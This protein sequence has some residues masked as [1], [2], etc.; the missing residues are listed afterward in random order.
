MRRPHAL[1]LTAAVVLALGACGKSPQRVEAAAADAAGER[2]VLAERT[3][4]DLKPVAALVTT[5]DMAEARARI[6]GTLVR[7]AVK[8]GDQVRKGQVVA[9][10][11]DQRLAF[12]TRAYEG[13]VAAA[14]AEATRAKAD[15]ARIQTLYDQGVYAEA[16]LEQAA[17]AA[18]AAQGQLDAVR[19]QRSAAAELVGQGDVL[20]P[21]SGRVLR[22][23]A[24][25]GSVV[26]PG[27]SVATIT[28]G[29]PLLRLEI[30]EA[31]A[32]A[33]RVGD[34]VPIMVEDL[35]G[36]G[37]AGVIEQV[38]PAVTAGRVVA[39]IRVAGLDSGLV[40]QRVRVRV[41]VGERQA[42]VI[43]RRFVATR[44]GVD[45]VRV[46]GRD[47]GA[48]D[49]AVQVAPGPV[50]D[51]VEVLSGLGRGDVIVAPPRTLAQGGTR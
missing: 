13:Q 38:Y 33:L 49:I 6:G 1:S 2:L 15:F 20:A 34:S 8:E 43:P 23:D 26:S 17:A 16:R 42:L 21:A 51:E 32:R 39:D 37:A 41:K 12:E 35:P 3:V 36:V 19:A 14:V 22:A 44:Y 50:A 47:G 40:G 24:P 10:V 46:A 25:A 28:A 11:T 4:A 18:R 30:P 9:V 5:K 48:A 31:Q 7:L 29:E 45:F 27:Q